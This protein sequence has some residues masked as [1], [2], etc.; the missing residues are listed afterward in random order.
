[1]PRVHSHYD[2]LKVSRSA[3]ADVIRAA[4]RT[5]SQKYHPDQNSGSAEAARIMAILNSSYDVL[6]NSE[7]RRKHDDWLNL[8]E[9]REND[10]IQSLR[11]RSSPSAE[12][13]KLKTLSAKARGLV[14]RTFEFLKALVISAFSYAAVMGAMFGVVW[15]VVTY[16]ESS[17][18]KSAP[19]V[20]PYVSAPTSSVPS[21]VRPTLAPNG[22]FWPQA[23]GYLKDVAIGHSGGLSTVTIDNTRNDSDVFVKLVRIGAKLDS[24]V[25][26]FY[27]LGGQ[28]FTLR[29]VRAGRFDV[30]HRDLGSGALSKS[31]EFQLTETKTEEGTRYSE[32]SITLYKIKNGNMQS[33]PIQEAEF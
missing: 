3:P 22:Q 7:L 2:N 20:K 29:N 12:N 32:I 19:P 21:Y 10:S 26:E 1:M 5:L 11:V 28:S 23:S 27:I 16:F 18:E 30:R 31:E 33:Y 17:K 24:P 8:E 25:R 9:A 14:M 13:S 15:L 4:Y 6:S